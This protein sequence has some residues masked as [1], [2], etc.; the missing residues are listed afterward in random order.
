M[1]CKSPTLANID[2][3][4]NIKSMICELFKVDYNEIIEL[5]KDYIT[6][7]VESSNLLY[8]EM[9]NFVSRSMQKKE[10]YNNFNAIHVQVKERIYFIKNNQEILVCWDNGDDQEIHQVPISEYQLDINFS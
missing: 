10:Q 5:D 8:N 4:L 7:T 9:M 6:F 3:E 1:A 2:S